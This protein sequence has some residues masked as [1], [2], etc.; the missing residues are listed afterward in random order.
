MT[1]MNGRMMAV[2]VMAALVSLLIAASAADAQTPEQD[3]VRAM[4]AWT[5][6]VDEGRYD[7]AW[8]QAAPAVQEHV[9]LPAWEA[10]LRGARGSL[11][12]VSGRV[13]ES[14]EVISAPPGA[15]AG[16]WVRVRFV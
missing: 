8:R 13:L 12:T 9:P 1:S 5:K 6:L 7:E 2:R 3:A 10:S 15:P 16:E 11:G 4:E 14:A